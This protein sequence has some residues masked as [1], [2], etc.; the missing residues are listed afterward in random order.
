M[1]IFLG[2]CSAQGEMTAHMVIA[3]DPKQLGP[4][5]KCKMANEL[6]LGICCHHF[7]LFNCPN[8]ARYSYL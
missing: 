4:V 8:G 1:I 7:I 5:V 6:G 2:V 3:G